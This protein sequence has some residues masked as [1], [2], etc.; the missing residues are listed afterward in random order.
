MKVSALLLSVVFATASSAVAQTGLPGV[1]QAQP[2]RTNRT[3]FR[4]PYQYNPDEISR[5]GA[6]EIRLF[7]SRDRGLQWHHVDTVSPAAGKFN[8]RSSGDGEY[9]FAVQ[10]V[11]NSGQVHPS[12]PVMQPGLIVVVDTAKPVLSIGLRQT[13][14]G[15]VELT[16]TS[17]DMDINP[18]SLTLEYTQTGQTGW[19]RVTVMPAA[20]GRT[21]WSV[22]MGGLVAVRGTIRDHAGNEA[23]SQ[24]QTQISPVSAS[25]PMQLPPGASHP[26]TG[27]QGT[28]SFPQA[29][30]PLP[31]PLT[32]NPVNPLPTQPPGPAAPVP[33]GAPQPAFQNNPLQSNPMPP[34]TTGSPMFSSQPP[35]T[36]GFPDN[37]DHGTRPME[38]SF[39]A[40][41][42]ATGFESPAAT[43]PA[44]SQPGYRTVNSRRFHIDYRIDDIGP[45]GVGA[46]DLFVTQNNGQKWYRYGIDDDRR[47]PFEV[48]VPGDG[49][50]GFSIR[51]AS[52]AGL[53]DAPPEPGEEPE[54]VIVV[55]SSPPVVQLFPLQQGTGPDTNRILITWEAADQKLAD[56]PVALSY[57]ANPNG[58]WEPISDW[59]PNSGRF[60]W[61]VGQ[62]IPARLYVRLIARDAAGNIARVDTPNPVLVDLARPSARIVDVDAAVTPR[63]TY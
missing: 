26:V 42:P 36:T 16:W 27:P 49:I 25:A 32:S 61:Q 56:R 3:A 12:G 40:A 7:V 54:I 24:F 59:L 21:T 50:Y 10:T 14:P 17:N 35:A 41:R 45:S 9:W 11:D 5:L 8:F 58:P 52:G 1:V 2:V 48:E 53:A 31:G 20:S 34:A 38:N 51:V 57:S 37:V 19:Q 47:S 13:E 46:V 18:Q 29:N 22:P 43:Q 33:P 55:D 6:R 44:A 4:I 62:G 60:V 23:A 39:V 30:R 15:R 63:R 28:P